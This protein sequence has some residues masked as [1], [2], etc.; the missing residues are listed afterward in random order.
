[1]RL[2]RLMQPRLDAPMPLWMI[3]PVVFAALY[4]THFALLRFPTTG[5]R[6]DITFPRRGTFSGPAR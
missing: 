3:F 1:L 4:S 6:R 5:T 2:R